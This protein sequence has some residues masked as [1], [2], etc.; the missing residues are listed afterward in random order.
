VNPLFFGDP[1]L[2]GV[3]HP[4]SGEPGPGKRPAVLVCPSIGHEHTRAQR[5]LRILAEALARGGRHV[6]RL[7]YRGLGDSWG[8]LEDGGVEPWC[9]DI[10]HALGQLAVLSG[11]QQIDV[12]GL[13]VG[14]ALAATALARGVGARG[15]TGR[16]VLWD[17]VLSGADF[18]NVAT[19]FQTAFLNDPMRFPALVAR[20]GQAEERPPGEDLLGYPYPADLRS[21][22]RGLDLAALTPWPAVATHIV[23]SEPLPGSDDLAAR[24]RTAG[25]RSSCEVVADADGAW[26]DYSRHELTLRAGKIVQIVVRR[27]EE[28]TA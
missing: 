24:L 4:P 21:S 6:L 13:R 5:A 7:D 17:P 16:L 26:Q 20:G 19:R 3:H 1:A 14:A 2:F 23:L 11:S 15:S 12:V 25:I 8:R 10:E 9:D 27:L 22:L 18:L 28:E